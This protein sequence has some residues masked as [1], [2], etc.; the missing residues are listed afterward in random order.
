M[1]DE[2]FAQAGPQI[3][4]ATIAAAKELHNILT[5]PFGGAAL[6]EAPDDAQ[7]GTV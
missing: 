1:P 6:T 4:K 7:V 3:L 2:V 5:C